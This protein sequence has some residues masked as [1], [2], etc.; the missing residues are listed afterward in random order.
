MDR[1]RRPTGS[2][3]D[4]ELLAALPAADRD[5]LRPD[6]EFVPLEY[7]K[8][9]HEP[10]Q[11]IPY[12][13][14][15]IDGVVSLVAMMANGVSVEVGMTG[16]QGMV[17]VSAILG[18]GRSPHS[19]FVQVPGAAFRMDASLARSAFDRSAAFRLLF[20]GYVALTLRRISQSAACNR[21][22][23]LEQRC[24]RWLLTTRDFVGRDEF[25]MTHEF[26]SLMLG[27]RRAGVSLAA[28]ALHESGLIDYRHGR[29]RIVDPTA[30]EGA[31]CEC[32][33]TLKDD[34]DRL[35]ARW[36]ASMAATTPGT[37]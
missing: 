12:V 4:N 32:Y 6:L 11:S 5:Q 1:Q 19:A 29:M 18:G 35:F 23:L 37:C 28:E 22:H 24:A 8:V 31:S 30:L 27:V 10:E 20:H 36:R 33:R 16:R 14:F 34:A 13:Y 2:L 7:R 26:L 15:P 25:P 3:E 17:G 9:L 21:V